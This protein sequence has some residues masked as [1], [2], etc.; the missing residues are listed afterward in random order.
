MEK[1]EKVRRK[2]DLEIRLCM[3]SM[4]NEGKPPYLD[5][6]TFDNYI[7]IVD[8][9]TNASL[10]HIRPTMYSKES[11]TMLFTAFYQSMG[12]YLK[13]QS[14]VFE[15]Y[16]MDGLEK[17]INDS[18]LLEN[19]YGIDFESSIL[20]LLL[21]DVV[22]NPILR[23]NWIYEIHYYISVIKQIAPIRECLIAK[24]S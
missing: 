21:E 11:S 18:C 23:Q 22:P 3:T 20:E 2:N 16:G 12:S 7:S 8:I 15:A 24:L 19:G 14:K 4:Y 6:D 10:L 13:A 1:Y 5:I 9:P 17:R